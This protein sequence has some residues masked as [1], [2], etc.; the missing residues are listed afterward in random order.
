[1][2]PRKILE[3]GIRLQEAGRPDEALAVFN[4]VLGKTIDD[5]YALYLT[6]TSFL[7]KGMFG[8][9]MTLLSQ[10]LQGE[11]AKSRQEGR[12]K[13]IWYPAAWNNLAACL[14]HEG[15]RDFA[16]KAFHTAMETGEDAATLGNLSGMYVNQGDPDTC[17]ALSRKALDLDPYQPQAGHHYAFG[18]LEK[19][20]YEEGFRW[21]NSR[22]RLPEFDHRNY[23]GFL[24][25]GSYVDTLVIHGEQ[26][27]GDEI[28]FASLINQAS[29]RV[30]KV[31]IE[32][33]G[34]LTKTFARSF[35]VPCYPDAK[36]LTE[37]EK[38]DAWIPMGSLPGVL[39][40]YAPLEHSGYLKPD[41]ER[42]KFW[43]KQYPFPRIGISWRGGTKFTHWE[44]RN[45]GIEEWKKLDA[46]MISLQYGEWS[47]EE[48]ELGLQVPQIKDFDDHMALVAACDLVI[49]VCN[50]TVHMAGSMNVPC[51]CLVPSKPAWRYGIKGDRMFW[52]PSVKLYRQTGEWSEVIERINADLGRLQG[53]QSLDAR[54]EARV[55]DDGVRLRLAYSAA[56]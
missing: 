24:W 7:T 28:M 12:D 33:A 10:A 50:T 17:I 23:P 40:A 42:V 38:P 14:K 2:H 47:H 25:D 37:K 54:D 20:E 44:L 19:G 31:V 32:C 55:R 22:L 11:E 34:K 13:D 15:H 56:V 45:F 16:I 43:K 35:G 3:K 21:Y 1:M 4:A 18:H 52:Y 39:E 51:W 30:G 29:K 53:A 41:P 26:G 5:P 9:A 48:R 27:V 8:V 49:S 46:R 36:S 6:G